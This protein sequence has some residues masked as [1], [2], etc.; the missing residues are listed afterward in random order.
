MVSGYRQKLSGEETQG[1]TYMRGLGMR[2]VSERRG[3][4]DPELLKDLYPTFEEF[5]WHLIRTFREKK[6]PF[7]RHFK[8]QTN[9][10]CI[11]YSMYDYIVPLEYSS[12]L[13][14]EVWSRISDTNISLLTSYDK[15]T[16]PRLQSSA[17][18]AKKWLSELD[19]EMAEDLYRIYKGDFMLMNYSNFSHADF[20]LPLHSRF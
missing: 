19:A 3:I 8:A 12:S 1:D 6:R 11:P 18:K 14:E 10:L 7:D 2:I 20:P 13:S 15:T 16:D 5:A 9:E 17:L 4:T